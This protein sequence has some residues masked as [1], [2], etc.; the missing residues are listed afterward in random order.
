MI[1]VLG[2]NNQKR[3]GPLI[4]SVNPRPN[5]LILGSKLFQ[6][7]LIWYDY[8][9]SILVCFNLIWSSILIWCKN[10]GQI[11]TAGSLSS[12]M[13]VCSVFVR[14]PF[15]LYLGGYNNDMVQG[16]NLLCGLI[17]M[18]LGNILLIVRLLTSHW[19]SSQKLG[20]CASRRVRSVWKSLGQVRFGSKMFRLKILAYLHSCILSY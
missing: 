6:L 5:T 20:R 13:L 10:L 16:N 1:W 11:V 9:I 2:Q 4:F 3:I 18:E 14:T 15:A 12:S 8:P 7:D 19:T 17:V